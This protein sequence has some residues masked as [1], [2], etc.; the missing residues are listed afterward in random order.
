MAN[1]LVCP[2]GQ[3]Q[4]TA[5][6]LEALDSLEQQAKD[7][8]GAPSPSPSQGIVLAHG[9]VWVDTSGGSAHCACSMPGDGT[10]DWSQM[11][12]AQRSALVGAGLITPFGT[13]LDD[14]GYGYKG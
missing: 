3:E 4:K 9:C 11:T 8:I 14:A 10:R 2:H 5:A 1:Q 13:M 12:S 6:L 7:D